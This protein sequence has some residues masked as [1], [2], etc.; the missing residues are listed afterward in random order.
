MTPLYYV[1]SVLPFA[2]KRRQSCKCT[3]LQSNAG[4]L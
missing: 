4:I 2:N 3:N 1:V